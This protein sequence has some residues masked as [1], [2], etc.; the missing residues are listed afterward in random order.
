MPN[1]R[2]IAITALLVVMAHCYA[3]SAS[4]DCRVPIWSH[5]VIPDLSGTRNGS[6]PLLLDPNRAGVLFLDN[7]RLLVYAVDQDI[8]QLSSRSRVDVSSPFRLRMWLLDASSGKQLLTNDVGTRVHGSAVQFT[9]AGLLIR[10]GQT[11]KVYS[12]DLNSYR[13]LSGNADEP[14]TVVMSSVSPNG[15]TIL[16]NHISQRAKTSS[17]E[18]FD[19]STLKL[20]T[21]WT[22][23]PPLYR[24]YSISN[25]EIAAA[26]NGHSLRL[27]KFGQNDWIPFESSQNCY[28]ASPA[29]VSDEYLVIRQ[30]SHLL[31]VPTSGEPYSLGTLDG[32]Q[33][34]KVATSTNGRFFALSVDRLLT[35]KHLFTEPSTGVVRTNL[36]VYDVTLKKQIVDVNIEPLP[37]NDYDF[38]L[39]PD[40]SRLAIL[41]DKTVSVCSASSSN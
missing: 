37:K 10:T 36:T 12:H 6:S 41:N 26:L 21:A 4:L 35:K 16:I 18:T 19:G 31:L 20:I 17:L 5:D 8:A 38:A 32:R 25:K 9:N 27:S 28:L 1:W 3:V 39:S 30:C 22:E 13:E 33:S 34:D 29:F 11:V 7:D 23:S 14:N 15:K 24:D 40:G 2:M